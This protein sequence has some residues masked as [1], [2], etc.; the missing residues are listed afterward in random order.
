MMVLAPMQKPEL[1]NSVFI[2]G[3]TASGK[4]S[5][6]LELAGNITHG[7]QAGGEIISLDSMQLWRGMDIGTAK[8][9]AEERR[10]VRHHLIELLE[11]SESFSVARYV[12]A[13]QAAVA[14]IAGR[15]RVPLFVGGTALYLKALLA[16]LFEGPSADWALRAELRR[17]AA[18][19]GPAHLHERLQS[20]D[21]GTAQRLHP[22][23]LRRIV[24]ALEVYEKTGTPISE[25]QRQWSAQRSGRQPP[26]FGIARD[27][28]GLYDRINRRVD[29]M[30]QGGL[31]DE[32]RRL[33]TMNPGREA[34]QA[35]GYRELIAHLAGEIPSLDEAVGLIKRNTR[36]FAKRQLTWFRAFTGIIWIEMRPG[37]SPQSAA[38]RI[39]LQLQQ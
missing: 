19:H 21:P 16:G 29:E 38:T 14:E 7:D 22:N 20:V 23:D 9:T 32:V 1:D 28:A 12:E 8:P 35:L 10:R 15:G 36:R 18:E 33:L 4:T 5:V 2:V 11:P 6:A 3:P 31:L 25:L 26:I 34:R 13:A 24:R 39:R 27:R 37:D 30:M 17:I